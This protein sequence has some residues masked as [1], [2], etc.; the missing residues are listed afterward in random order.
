MLP[1]APPV[2]LATQPVSPPPAMAEIS[3]TLA[4]VH[5]RRAIRIRGIR[6]REEERCELECY[7]NGS[8]G[9]PFT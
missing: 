6:R 3:F 4:R 7:T 8:V 5:Y 9:S 1:S 2:L